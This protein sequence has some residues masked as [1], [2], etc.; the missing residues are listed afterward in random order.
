MCESKM[1]P[2]SE[3]MEC[4]CITEDS[5]V[6]VYLSAM[7]SKENCSDT[8]L[9]KIITVV[10]EVFY[11]YS[12]SYFVGQKIITYVNSVRGYKAYG[13]EYLLIVTFFLLSFWI[14]KKF[15]KDYRRRENN[16]SDKKRC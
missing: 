8:L 7:Q 4:K 5:K 13:G 10:L 16:G 9:E 6:R 11:S 2:V 3:G 15:F 12:A 14:I 1:Y